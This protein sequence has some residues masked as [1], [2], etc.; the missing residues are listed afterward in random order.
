MG[1]F[2]FGKKKSRSSSS[3]SSFGSQQSFGAQGSSGASFGQSFVDQQQ[4]PFLDFLRNQAQGAFGGQQQS[5]QDLQGLFG[6]LGGE[7]VNNQFLQD[8]RAQSG[9]NPELVAAQ[10]GQLSD[11]LSQQFNEQINPAISRQAQGLGQL[12]GGRQ[13]VAQGQAIQGQQR[14]LAA[15]N[16]GFQQADAQRAQQA[17]LGGGQLQ[18]QGIG[19]AG[20][21]A[22]QGFGAQFAPGQQLQQLFGAPTVLSQQGAVDQ[23][24]GFD[25]ARQ[26]QRSSGTS[27]G[28]SSGFNFG[29]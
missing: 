12:G 26:F 5:A 15:G 6:N 29:F 28:K 13:G 22:Q 4:A 27:S 10:T 21:F 25:Q 3:Q 9:G 16:V 24:F 17:A 8:L 18:G 19:Q 23:S 20:Q 11:V 1:L 14:A 7:A 2:S